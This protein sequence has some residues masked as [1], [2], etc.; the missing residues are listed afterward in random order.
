MLLAKLF[1]LCL[2]RLLFIKWN[3]ARFFS[4]RYRTRIK[5]KIPAH[6]KTYICITPKSVL[7]S[8]KLVKLQTVRA[9]TQK[10]K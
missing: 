3:T 10:R 9:V 8:D 7:K 1:A 4:D 2:I 6:K 5:K